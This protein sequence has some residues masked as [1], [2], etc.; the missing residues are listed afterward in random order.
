MP[1]PTLPPIS[2]NYYSDVSNTRGYAQ[3]YHFDVDDRGARPR[4]VPIPI[5]GNLPCCINER[6]SSSPHHHHQASINTSTS[7]SL[8][9]LP[10]TLPPSVRTATTL[11]TTE[12]TSRTTPSSHAISV[13]P[14]AEPMLIVHGTGGGKSSIY[15]TVGFVKGGVSLIIQNTLSLSS[16]QLSKLDNATMRSKSIFAYQLDSIKDHTSREAFKAFVGNQCRGQQI[17]ATSIFMH[18]ILI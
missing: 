16:D 13:Y 10:S 17:I 2:N 4:T 1:M 6:Q 8:S 14:P 7:S 18:C 9:L 12:A 15:Q 11:N 3:F 5:E